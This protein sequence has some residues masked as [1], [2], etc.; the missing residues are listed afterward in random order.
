MHHR[1]N[2]RY[3][4]TDELVSE[5]LGKGVVIETEHFKAVLS[6]PDGI[7]NEEMLKVETKPTRLEYKAVFEADGSV[8]EQ[9]F[10]ELNDDL[11]TL[12]EDIEGAIHQ[13]WKVRFA[14]AE[15]MAI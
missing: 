8:E 5:L 2:G 14:N 11:D 7:E 6:C 12:R 15:R 4:G 9:M 3:Y 1:I 13:L 10:D